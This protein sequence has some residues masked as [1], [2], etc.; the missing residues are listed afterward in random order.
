MRVSRILIKSFLGIDELDIKPGAIVEVTGPNGAGKT[1]IATAIQSIRNGGSMGR[2]IRDGEDRSEVLIQ[3]SDG[4]DI[5]SIREMITKSKT[6]RE[7]RRNGAPVKQTQAA[8]EEIFDALSINPIEFV[9]GDLK[10][11]REWL[12]SSL[13]FSVTKEDFERH[14]LPV[15]AA[16]LPK[17]V[18]ADIL[19]VFHKNYYEF[20]HGANLQVKNLKATVANLQSSIPTDDGS[21]VKAKLAAAK[22]V[23]AERREKLASYHSN[24]QRALDAAIAEVTATCQQTVSSLE[25]QILELQA[26]IAAA[27]AQRDSDIRS[28]RAEANASEGYAKAKVELAES[29]AAVEAAAKDVESYQRASGLRTELDKQSG[30]LAKAE[31][32]AKYW[33]QCLDNL[34]ALKTEVLARVPIKG[35]EIRNGEFWYLDHLLDTQNTASKLGLAVKVAAARCKAARLVCIDGCECL[36]EIHLEGLKKLAERENLQLVITRV[37]PTATEL[38][39]KV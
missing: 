26:C 24:I 27:Q 17:D 37:V 5:I 10:K 6:T 39:V 32:E 15:T 3:L 4:E 34:A 29:I 36:D 28:F 22:D 11:Q 2:F 12:L 25:K 13:N 14:G 35:L 7:V 9:N 18:G 20:R 31:E 30:S 21:A 1:S 33:Q 38:D 23:E 19:D 16:E 8:I